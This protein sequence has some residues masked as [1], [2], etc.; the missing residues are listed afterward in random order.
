MALRTLTILFLLVFGAATLITGL[1]TYSASSQ[2][3]ERLVDRRIADVSSAV[4]S[5]ASPGDKASILALIDTFSRQRASGDV[6][7]E[8]EDAAGRR[9][10]G[11]VTLARPVPMGFSTLHPGDRIAGL[12]SGRAEM[13]DAGGGLRLITIIETEPI[14]GFTRVQWRNYL[15][16]FGSI[17]AIVL[18]GTA[19]FGILVRHRITDVRRTAEAIIDGDM[20]RRVPRSGDGGVF[21]A[22]AA[23]FN[24]MLDRI[25]SL[26]ESVRNVSSDVA[27][28]LRT[29]LARLRGRLQRIAGAPLA[30][31]AAIELDAAVEQCDEILAIFAAIL[32]IA[33]LEGNERRKAFA[34]VDLAEIAAGVIAALSPAASES[35]HV[36][37]HDGL[38]SVIVDG[39]GASITQAVFNLVE[40]ALRHTPA[41]TAIIVSAGQATGTATLAVRD[42]GPGITH[43]DMATAL[44]RFGRINPSRSAPGHGLG[45]PLVEAVARLHRGAL[46]LANANPGLLA[47]LNLPLRAEGGPAT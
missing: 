45:L 43:A 40:N 33:E 12:S 9:L 18:A 15:L 30:D 7:F 13:R 44:R 42:H 46:T 23:A 36:L 19:I 32:R 2:A 16:G 25:E 35:G 24:R 27:H 41:G 28:D 21:D 37:I 29:P 20:K 14:D 5:Q 6:G 34:R 4:L 39:D 22:Q 17:A 11:N 38:S 31:D 1:A 8:L 10:G 26:L 47:M 3:L